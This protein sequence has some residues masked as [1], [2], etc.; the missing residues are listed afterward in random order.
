MPWSG[1]SEVKSAGGLK[2][3]GG[4]GGPDDVDEKDETECSDGRW[5]R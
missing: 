5:E 4:I 2:S 1:N 3:A